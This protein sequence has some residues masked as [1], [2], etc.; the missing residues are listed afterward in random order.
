MFIMLSQTSFAATQN[1]K[2]GSYGT[3]EYAPNG[4]YID[5]AEQDK[6]NI[7]AACSKLDLKPMQWNVPID[8]NFVITFSH[9]ID[10][11]S[12]N[13]KT[14]M[15]I[16]VFD[17]HNYLWQAD[18]DRKVEGNKIT[19][20]PKPQ[21]FYACNYRIII[22]GVKSINGGSM[23]KRTIMQF[24]TEDN[25][26]D[27]ITQNYNDTY[28]VSRNRNNLAD[29]AYFSDMEQTSW[30]IVHDRVNEYYSDSP[31]VADSVWNVYKR[32]IENL[33]IYEA[34]Y[35]DAYSKDY[36]GCIYSADNKTAYIH[37][38]T[39]TTNTD[40]N[41]IKIYFSYSYQD[42]SFNENDPSPLD[43]HAYI[44]N[45][46]KLVLPEQFIKEHTFSQN[47]YMTSHLDSE[48]EIKL[49]KVDNSFR[50]FDSYILLN[51]RTTDIEK[52]E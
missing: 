33:P 31:K 29:W 3:G 2:Y 40:S 27:S 12:V 45:N 26:K 50:P 49:Y 48:P 19:I 25:K 35:T 44:D 10:P 14:V 43:E 8:K 30:S 38:L 52:G 5:Y 15:A 28:P 32:I 4:N 13:D 11:S 22:D 23:G 41:I 34:V 36:P 24:C 37:E 6:T 9:D 46:G 42:R 16:D 20:T 17:S 51:F 39:D 21:W 18:I 7:D 47:S 1:W